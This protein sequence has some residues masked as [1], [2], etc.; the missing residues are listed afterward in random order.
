MALLTRSVRTIET[1]SFE[2]MIRRQGLWGG[3]EMTEAN[4]IRDFLSVDF[5]LQDILCTVDHAQPDQGKRFQ[6]ENSR[7]VADVNLCLR[8]RPWLI[9]S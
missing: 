2:R 5:L 4:E 6:L 3:V 9:R 7:G 1:F 8:S